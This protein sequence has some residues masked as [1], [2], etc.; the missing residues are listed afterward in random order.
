MHPSR[1]H[2]A[3]RLGLC[4]ALL[5][6]LG[7]LLA[8]QE[9]QR[10]EPIGIRQDHVLPLPSTADTDALEQALQRLRS[11][12]PPKPASGLIPD[13][14]LLSCS[15]LYQLPPQSGLPGPEAWQGTPSTL[16]LADGTRLALIHDRLHAQGMTLPDGSTIL[17]IDDKGL[18]LSLEGRQDFIAWHAPLE[19]R[20]TA[21]DLGPQ[22]EAFAHGGQTPDD[23]TAVRLPTPQAF[24]LFPALAASG[25]G[26]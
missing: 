7:A 17:G 24:T 16:L 26:E 23:N 14:E 15:A 12:E 1:W 11:P 19:V 5:L 8:L 21:E 13:M 18:L 25:M 20:L 9:P 4:L 22:G 10:P 2:V 6:G 3:F